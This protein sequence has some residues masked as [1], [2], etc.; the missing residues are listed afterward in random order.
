MFFTPDKKV[1]NG[2]TYGGI[3]V[4]LVVCTVLYIVVAAILTGIVP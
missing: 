1:D 3:I 4:S 2:L